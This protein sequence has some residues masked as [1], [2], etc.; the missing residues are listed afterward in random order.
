MFSRL[1]RQGD[2]VE[3]RLQHMGLTFGSRALNG[4]GQLGD[5]VNKIG[6]REG[7]TP[8]MN[9]IREFRNP[10]AFV[11]L[12]HLA[13]LEPVDP[14][15]EAPARPAGVDNAV[16]SRGEIAHEFEPAS[17]NA[18]EPLEKSVS[19][20]GDRQASLDGEL[21]VV[22]EVDRTL[23]VKIGVRG[24]HA[25]VANDAHAVIIGG[26]NRAGHP[27]DHPAAKIQTGD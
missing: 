3:A 24:E 12:S 21:G 20:H 27:S 5:V 2:G 1:F 6:R 23:V 16:C 9:R 10:E 18:K 25:L 8:V 11:L 4:Q 15:L 22:F 19:A 7:L 13:A 17:A 14:C 26:A